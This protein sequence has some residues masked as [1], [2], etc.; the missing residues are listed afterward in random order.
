M[1]RRST[2]ILSVLT[3]AYLQAGGF[4]TGLQASFD[5]G[6]RSAAVPRVDFLRV[7]DS[8]A[9]AASGSSGQV[10]ATNNVYSLGCDYNYFVVGDPRSRGA[11]LAAGVGLAKGSLG[12]QGSLAGGPSTRADRQQW[13]AFPE[14][15][16]GYLFMRHLGAEILYKD[17]RFQ[18]V[19]INLS[20]QPVNHSFDRAIE[21]A[22]F[23]R[24]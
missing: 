15:G 19:G 23:I 12:V 18:D 20:G 13:R 4:G 3:G 11:Y 1:K 16:I 9:I 22:L 2:L 17:F 6:G 8:T 10:S 7:T 24:F 5:L 14:A 21:V